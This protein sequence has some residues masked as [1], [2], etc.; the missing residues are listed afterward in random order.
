MLPSEN[1]TSLLETSLLQTIFQRN[2]VWGNGVP[3]SEED[4][5]RT[6][7][8]K[9]NL[10]V[11]L[12]NE[13]ENKVFIYRRI[14]SKSTAQPDGSS[15]SS[16]IYLFSAK[17]EEDVVLPEDEIGMAKTAVAV[18]RNATIRSRDSPLF[19]NPVNISVNDKEVVIKSNKICKTWFFA[20]DQ[21]GS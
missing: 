11:K 17:V 4:L 16:S 5:I 13:T 9:D 14:Q 8:V 7:T 6:R 20:G 12:K 3:N 15:S 10:L 18:L 19:T 1:Q 21:S 2:L